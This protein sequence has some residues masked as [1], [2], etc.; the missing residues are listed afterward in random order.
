MT[1]K[2]FQSKYT[3]L[4]KVTIII[5]FFETTIVLQYVCFAEESSS[6]Y[7]E[8]PGFCL[9]KTFLGLNSFMNVEVSIVMQR[10]M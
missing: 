4:Y 9:K 5:F 3:V 1:A 10:E 8:N 7:F 2:I 6:S